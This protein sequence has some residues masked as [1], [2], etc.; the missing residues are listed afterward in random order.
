MEQQYKYIKCRV[1]EVRNGD[2]TVYAFINLDAKKMS[3]KY[4]MCTR[5]PNWNVPDIKVGQEGILAYKPVI[6]GI[7]RWYNAEELTFHPYRHSANYFIDF[8][9]ITH[10]IDDNRVVKKELFI[11]K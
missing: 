6:A 4:L 2:Y 8:V 9:P 1:L 7:D 3:K 5:L 10:I 11:V